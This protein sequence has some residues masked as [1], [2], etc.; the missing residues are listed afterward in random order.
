[1][2][3]CNGPVYAAELR[4]S[5]II[6]CNTR[7]FLFLFSIYSSPLPPVNMTYIL[8]DSEN[9]FPQW[10]PHCGEGVPTPHSTPPHLYSGNTLPM[11]IRIIIS[12]YNVARLR[13]II[14]FFKSNTSG[15]KR[16]VRWRRAF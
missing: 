13:V 12:C 3:R 11:C 1:M 9:M 8:M 15:E 16:F 14:G 7:I 2:N 5:I 10:F 4:S 6:L